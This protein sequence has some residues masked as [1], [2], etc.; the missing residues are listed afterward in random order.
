MNI[1][2]R[3]YAEHRQH[4]KASFAELDK[5]Q[6]ELSPEAARRAIKTKAMLL[7][8]IDRYSELLAHGITHTWSA[9]NE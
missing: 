1:H 2:P 8:E 5:R 7:V 6:A 3:N 4:L 9:K